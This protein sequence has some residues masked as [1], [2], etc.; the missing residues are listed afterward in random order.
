MNLMLDTTL[1]GFSIVDGDRTVFRADDGSIAEMVLGLLC[2]SD[3]ARSGTFTCRNLSL[4]KAMLLLA[5]T[6]AEITTEA[7]DPRALKL[8]EDAGITVT[9]DA[10][11][12]VLEPVEADST[13]IARLVATS[14]SPEMLRDHL[15]SG[16][17]A[18]LQ[19]YGRVTDAWT[20]AR[21]GDYVGNGGGGGT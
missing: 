3:E 13:G 11:H 10:I 4:T 21:H 12:D 20:S 7:I 19:Q 2:H 15:A 18:A 5:Y 9:A 17:I 16:M 6:P 1:A 8:L 14:R